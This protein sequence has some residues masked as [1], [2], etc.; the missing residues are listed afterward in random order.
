MPAPRQPENKE[1]WNTPPQDVVN[2]VYGIANIVNGC[3]TPFLRNGFGSRGFAAHPISLIFMIGYAGF[4]NC[5][6]MSLYIPVWLLFV[7]MRQLKTNKN[8]HSRYQG[9]PW[10]C[11]MIPFVN[12]EYKARTVE[13]WV[14]FFGG[15]FLMDV[16]L[17]IGQL[18]IIG[19]A[20]LFVVLMIE[21]ASISARKRAMEDARHEAA[22][23][24]DL[25]RGGDGW[26]D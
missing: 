7:L 23:M 3:F 19:C 26:G 22:Q 16:S 18:L 13:P 9:Y 6:E 8:Q 15:I 14:L 25:Q 10:L 5:P 1:V 24:A 4:A 11:R 20:T 2:I 21:V 12:T 17:G